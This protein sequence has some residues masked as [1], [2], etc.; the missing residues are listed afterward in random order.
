MKT[1]PPVQVYLVAGGWT[2]SSTLA[3]T[4]LLVEG[5][6]SWTKVAPL[7]RALQGLDIVSIN[8]Q[9]ILTGESTRWDRS[10]RCKR[11]DQSAAVVVCLMSLPANGKRA[12]TYIRL[13]T[14][15]NVSNTILSTFTAAQSLNSR[16]IRWL[17]LW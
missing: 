8:N 9:V 17:C 13:R 1:S 15:L 4:E 7:P 12:F 10:V 6:L 2:G 11:T 14:D 16:R 3:S 5:T